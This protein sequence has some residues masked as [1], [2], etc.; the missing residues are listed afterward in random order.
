[1]QFRE[2]SVEELES[3]FFSKILLLEIRIFEL[4]ATMYYQRQA[5]Y[6]VEYLIF[7]TIV[8]LSPNVLFMLI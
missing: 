8:D 6:W 2:L 1:M 4:A 5:Q 7:K 3:Y